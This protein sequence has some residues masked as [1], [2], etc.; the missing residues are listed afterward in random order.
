VN[1]ETIVS[2]VEVMQRKTH[3]AVITLQK[4]L[5]KLNVMSM[6]AINSS[7]LSCTTAEQQ[8]RMHTI[9]VLESDAAE[10]KHNAK[11]AHALLIDNM[12]HLDNLVPPSLRSNGARSA[13]KHVRR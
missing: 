3:E 5:K 1:D 12:A 2:N 4:L 8:E 6:K 7:V 9:A 13:V 11:A 10:A